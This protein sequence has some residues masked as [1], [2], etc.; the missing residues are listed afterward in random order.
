MGVTKFVLQP[1][2]KPGDWLKQVELIAKH[3]IKPL[4]TPFSKEEVFERS[5][6]V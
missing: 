6:V 5:G 2:A 1:L 3:V 4:Q